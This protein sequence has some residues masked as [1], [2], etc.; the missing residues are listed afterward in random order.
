MWTAGFANEDRSWFWQLRYGNTA[1]LDYTNWNTGEPNDSGGNEDAIAISIDG[2]K[3]ND[4]P[5]TK[6]KCF[7]C[8]SQP[9]KLEIVICW[10]II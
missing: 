7:I 8:E 9:C 6:I 2:G 5:P 3:W 1:L 4:I 10:F